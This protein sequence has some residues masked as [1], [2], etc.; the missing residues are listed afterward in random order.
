MI[1]TRNLVPVADRGPLRVLFLITSMPVG[2]AETLLVNLVRRMNRDAFEPEIGCLKEPGPLGE[3]MAQEVPVHSQ[4]LT[5]KYDLRVWGRLSRLCRDRRID[6]VITVGAGDKMFWG[7]LAAWRARVPVVLSAL[8][9]TGW[10]DGVGKLNRLLTPITDGFIA[11]AKKHGRFLA[12]HERFP[13]EKVH[14]IPNGVDCDRFAPEPGRR[15]EARRT[16]GLYPRSL[17]CGIVAAL[18]PEKNH[19]LFLKVASLIARRLPDARFFIIG[20]GPERKQLEATAD[21]LG[22]MP[23]TRFL[24]SRS[25]IPEILSALDLFMLTSKNEANPVSILEAMAS[26]LPVVTTNVGS[27]AEMVVDGETG[28]LEDPEDDVALAGRA[29]SLLEDGAQRE[30]FGDAGRRRVIEYGSLETMVR[31]YEQLIREIYERKQSGADRSSVAII[32]RSEVESS[33]ELSNSV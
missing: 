8:H 18:R 7:R 2:G 4:L 14:V 12:E 32:E 15:V 1:G 9:S 5:G 29:L 24:G 26:G 28:Y 11:V 33:R 16:L 10:P 17:A 30:A 27:I 22:L 6:A 21:Y 31:G 20:D 3:M 13:A 25:D 19:L 23:Q